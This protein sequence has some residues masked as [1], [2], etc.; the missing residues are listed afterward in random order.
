M[1]HEFRPPPP[2]KSQA[3]LLL[4]PPVWV[5]NLPLSL[6]LATHPTMDRGMTTHPTGG[7]GG[8]GASTFPWGSWGLAHI[9]MCFGWRPHPPMICSERGRA[10][11]CPPP[12]Y[13]SAAMFSPTPWYGQILPR[14]LDPTLDRFRMSKLSQDASRTPISAER[15]R[16]HPHM[17]GSG[18]LTIPWGGAAANTIPWGNVGGVGCGRAAAL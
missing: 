13:G 7:L 9:I 14:A 16:P 12:W 2:Q 5:I 6:I 18:H 4:L 8:E 11:A 15:T 1:S 3:P 10:A 17:G